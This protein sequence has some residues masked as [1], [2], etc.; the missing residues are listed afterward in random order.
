MYRSLDTRM[1]EEREDLAALVERD[2]QRLDPLVRTA[3]TAEELVAVAG[4][5][6]LADDLGAAARLDEHGVPF[7]GQAAEERGDRHVER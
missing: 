3:Q 4:A 1:L 7:L 5:G 6:A 2:E